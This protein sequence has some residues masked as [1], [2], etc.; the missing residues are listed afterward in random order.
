[1]FLESPIGPCQLVGCV[2][3]AKQTGKCLLAVC[4][5]GPDKLKVISPREEIIGD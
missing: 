4:V 3:T 1:M 2:T 5:G